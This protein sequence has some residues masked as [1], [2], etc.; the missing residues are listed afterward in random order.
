MLQLFNDM[1]EK[2]TLDKFALDQI[3]SYMKEKSVTKEKLFSMSAYFPSIAAKN[4]IRSGV[5]SLVL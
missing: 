1:D 2:D 4:M 3:A 5:L